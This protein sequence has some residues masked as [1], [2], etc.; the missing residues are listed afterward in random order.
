MANAVSQQEKDEAESNLI[1]AEKRLKLLR[2]ITK[3]ALNGATD[4]LNRT[5]KLY[6][7]GMA[8]GQSLGEL[9]A[10]VQMLELILQ[11]A[12]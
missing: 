10:K 12:D 11:S 1:T 3:V 2:G 8:S 7:T 4:E 6:Q 5:Q 9:T